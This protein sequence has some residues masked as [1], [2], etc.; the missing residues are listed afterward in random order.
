MTSRV[1]CFICTGTVV[2]WCVC[3]CVCV[4]LADAVINTTNS[5]SLCDQAM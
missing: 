4:C 1:V 5:S 3:V 2:E